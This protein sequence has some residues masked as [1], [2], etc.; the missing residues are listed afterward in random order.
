M[1]MK[2]I[3][4]LFSTLAALCCYA[5]PMKNPTG[6]PFVGAN[7][8]TNI[9]VFCSTNT[10]ALK[11]M[12]N[13]AKANG[14]GLSGTNFAA[15]TVTNLGVVSN[16]F[17]GQFAITGGLLK[18]DQAQTVVDWDQ[19]QLLDTYGKVK[20]NWF[21]G[22][23]GDSAGFGSVDTENRSLNNASG[24][25]IFSWY[26]EINVSGNLVATNPANVFV[27]SFTNA[28]GYALAG[29]NDSTNIAVFCSTNTQALQVMTNIAKANGWSGNTIN[30]DGS[31]NAYSSGV[32]TNVT[33]PVVSGYTPVTIYKGFGVNNTANNTWSN[34][35]SITIPANSLGTNRCLAVTVLGD[36]FQNTGGSTNLALCVMCNTTTN[37]DAIINVTTSTSRFPFRMDLCLCASNSASVQI[38]EGSLLCGSTTQAVVGE[39]GIGLALKMLSN[40]YGTSSEDSTQPLTFVFKT[41]WS[42]TSSSCEFNVRYV[43]AKIE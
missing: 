11:V 20:Y 8:S 35:F 6:Y 23:L 43:T 31:T 3:T 30:A 24:V 38:M 32:L 17:L 26:S 4:I 33:T 34:A 14:G 7:E 9:A 36:I 41:L 27:G 1:I 42:S 28:A 40:F 19:D 15:I 25:G 22:L 5:Q 10:A 13:I 12:T 2:Y 16:I 37:W 29:L 21:T 18:N 39:G